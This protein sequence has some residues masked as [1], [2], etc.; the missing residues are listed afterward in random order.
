V[1]AAEH[2]RAMP[3]FAELGGDDLA[4][5][6]AALDVRDH[7][8]GHVFIREGSHADPVFV[9]LAGAVD[10][11]RERGDSSQRLNRMVEGDLFGL[12][13]L[14]DDAPRSATCRAAGPCTIG[15]WPGSVAKLL[16]NQRA[17]IARAFQLAL[18]RQLA[19]DFRQI[20]QQ[21]RARLTPSTT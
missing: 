12:I 5:L 14:V 17:A 13:A 8:G 16:F 3:H 9:V 2:L 19:R 7:P 4:A 20:D 11:V 18:A 10:V 15:E 6:V 21:V 1:N